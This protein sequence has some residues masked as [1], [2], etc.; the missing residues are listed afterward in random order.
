MG[1]FFV[2]LKIYGNL[3]VY[4]KKVVILQSDISR[5]IGTTIRQVRAE[6]YRLST[7]AARISR[8]SYKLTPRIR[9][10]YDPYRCGLNIFL[11][12]SCWNLNDFVVFFV[13]SNNTFWLLRHKEKPSVN[14]KPLIKRL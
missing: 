3:T 6:A 2:F 8:Q 7:T 14:T 13:H 10:S 11:F 5:E 9:L 4:Y 12:V 1:L